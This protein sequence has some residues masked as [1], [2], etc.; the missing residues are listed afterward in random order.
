MHR[1]TFLTGVFCCTIAALFAGAEVLNELFGDAFHF[2]LNSASG[3]YYPIG[4]K[5]ALATLIF[6]IPTAAIFVRMGSLLAARSLFESFFSLI[7]TACATFAL[8]FFAIVQLRIAIFD[9]TPLTAAD[10]QAFKSAALVAL[11]E[12]NIVAFYTFGAFLSLA[13]ISLRPY[14]QLRSSRFLA[15]I[16]CIPL[17]IYLALVA[18]Q[19]LLAL[20]AEAARGISLLSIAFFSVLAVLFLS[21]A[22]HSLRHRHYFLEATNLRSLMEPRIDTQSPDDRRT[23][24]FRN[25]DVAFEG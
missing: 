3:S 17:P 9:R 13:I 6:A 22:V 15:A 18:Q 20:R 2:W 10:G 25:G 24:R 19:V 12:L 1:A 21:I 16:V 8:I 11:T 5:F 23:P 7:A 4:G 14:F